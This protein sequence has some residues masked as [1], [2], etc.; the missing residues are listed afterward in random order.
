MAQTAQTASTRGLA[1]G[2]SQSDMRQGERLPTAQLE[3]VDTFGSLELP[4]WVG[5]SRNRTVDFG[6]HFTNPRVATALWV[7]EAQ[8]INEHTAHEHHGDKA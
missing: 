7:R 2:I 4:E 5:V 1:H 8:T 6:D 3:A